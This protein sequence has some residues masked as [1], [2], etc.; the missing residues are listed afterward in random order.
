MEDEKIPYSWVG[1]DIDLIS[2]DANPGTHTE[3]DRGVVI[4]DLGV[5]H[6]TS[7]KLTSVTDHGI[8]VES[9]SRQADDTQVFYPWGSVLRILLSRY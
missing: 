8:V 2:L 9:V 4:Y 1:Q 6:I 5:R 3:I 7:L